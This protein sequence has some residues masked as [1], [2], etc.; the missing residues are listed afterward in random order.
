MVVNLNSI[1]TANPPGAINLRVTL[2]LKKKPVASLNVGE[3]VTLT[4]TFDSMG[5]GTSEP[6]AMYRKD[7]P[8]DI[9]I[10]PGN[11]AFVERNGDRQIALRYGAPGG[12]EQSVTFTC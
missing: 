7:S 8:A 6:M 11:L 4:T 10:D 9:T 3:A 1:P 12:T 2:F 5:V